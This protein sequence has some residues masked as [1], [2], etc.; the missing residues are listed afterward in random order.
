MELLP[1]SPYA[2]SEAKGRAKPTAVDFRSISGNSHTLRCLQITIDQASGS[3][4]N[5]DPEDSFHV[6]VLTA[7]TPLATSFNAD[8][9]LQSPTTNCKPS[10]KTQHELRCSV[11]ALSTDTKE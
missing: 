5:G 9:S 10:T 1:S 3:R 2:V 8:A 6:S 4:V 7:S 11:R